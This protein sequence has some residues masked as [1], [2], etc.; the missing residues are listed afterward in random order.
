MHV[1]LYAHVPLGLYGAY[2]YTF[3]GIQSSFLRQEAAA[4]WRQEATAPR[5]FPGIQVGKL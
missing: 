5:R 3:I 4:V 1:F 2:D